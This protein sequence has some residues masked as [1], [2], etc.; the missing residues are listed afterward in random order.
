LD[1]LFLTSDS[2][3]TLSNYKLNFMKIERIIYKIKEGVFKWTCLHKVRELK[4][5]K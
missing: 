2:N 3:K 5:F 4:K 1:F